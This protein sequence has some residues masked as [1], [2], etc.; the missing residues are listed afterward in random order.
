MLDGGDPVAQL[1]GAL[2]VPG[3]GGLLH[4]L[5]ERG[6]DLVAA[7][8]EEERRAVDRL[9][10]GLAVDRRDAGRGALVQVVVEADLVV[11]GDLLLALAVGEEPVEQVERA[12]G[13]AGRGVRTEVAAAVVDDPAGRDDA[14]PLLVGDLEVR[15]RLAVLQHDVVLGLVL[16]ISSFSR[17]S[18]SVAV[19]VRMTS[20]SAM[21]ATS[22]RVLRV[23]AAGRLEVGADAVAQARSPCRRR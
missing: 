14:R 9:H 13:G 23:H 22:S 11:A 7:A 10:V 8:V 17:I 6:E 16:L 21:W 1:G 5:F 19:S 20:K 2:E 12:V 18:A 4:L 3:V 15:V